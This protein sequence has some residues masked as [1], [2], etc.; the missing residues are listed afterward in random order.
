MNCA[1]DQRRTG[2]VGVQGSV[3]EQAAADNDDDDDG[4]F[5]KFNDFIKHYSVHMHRTGYGQLLRATFQ[6]LRD[7][8]QRQVECSGA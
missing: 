8:C 4:N 2:A 1:L 7:P 3:A 5:L 6:P